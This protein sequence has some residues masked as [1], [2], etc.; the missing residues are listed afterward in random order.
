[1]PGDI[2]SERWAAWAGIINPEATNRSWTVLTRVCALNRP[3][4]NLRTVHRA[5]EDLPG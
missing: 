1:M 2:K 4:Q 5:M 3:A